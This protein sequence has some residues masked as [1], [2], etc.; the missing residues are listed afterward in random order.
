[1]TVDLAFLSLE[2]A[3]ARLGRG[4]ISSIDLTR[5]ALA[6][7]DRMESHTN[8]LAYRLD[9]RALEQAAASDERRA[10]GGELGPLDGI[11]YTLK[12]IIDVAGIPT[13]AGSR[14]YESNVPTESATLATALE[15][16]GAVLLAKA[17]TH[18]FA[19]GGTTLP[20]RNAW[21]PER[22]PGGSSGGS[23][24]A[25][26]SGI[27]VFTI[28]TDTAGSVRSPANFNGISGLKP[29]Y[30]KIG[31]SGVVPLAWTLDTVGVLARSV[32]DVAAVYDAV[33]GPDPRDHTSI[34]TPHEPIAESIAGGVEGLRVGVP[35]RGF[36]DTI[37]NSVAQEVERGLHALEEAGAELVP[38][39]LSPAE[40]VDSALTSAFILIGAESAAWHSEWIDTKGDLYGDDVRYYLEMGRTIPAT[41]YID[42]QRTRQLVAEAFRAAFA[43]VD[44]VVTP[45]HGHIAPRVDEEIVVFDEGGRVHR[46]PAGVRNLAIVNMAGLPGLTVPTGLADGLPAGIQLIGPPL[47]EA[48]VL[49]AGRAVEERVGHLGRRPPLAVK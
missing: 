41:T 12:D 3:G 11:P 5:A 24:S 34:Q 43:T 21:D 9:E 33:A 28:G 36:F 14:L 30:G 23:A 1:M 40:A 18:E 15:T 49:R 16:A 29:T 19:W 48:L 26:A 27:G 4:E 6:Q 45:G 8:P 25:V 20:A 42:A 46:D 22:I 37:Q 7:A 47:D 35:D 17:R 10:E 44:L 39:T 32:A 2:E 31:R 38:I 13:G